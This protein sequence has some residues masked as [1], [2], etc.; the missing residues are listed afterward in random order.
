MRGDKCP[1]FAQR[2]QWNSEACKRLGCNPLASARTAGFRVECSEEAASPQHQ[3]DEFTVET[4]R[5]RYEDWELR[6]DHCLGDRLWQNANRSVTCIDPGEDDVTWIGGEHAT[7]VGRGPVACRYS[8]FKCTVIG[9]QAPNDPVTATASSRCR[10]TSRTGAN[11]KRELRSSAASVTIQGSSALHRRIRQRRA[12]ENPARPPAWPPRR[13][14]TRMHARRRQAA[15][16]RPA[17]SRPS[18][19]SR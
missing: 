5:F 8:P 4:V 17:R 6:R 13:P 11:G 2:W 9:V 18:R 16:D 10:T 19:R 14:T 3:L 1:L 15:A 12:D 7:L